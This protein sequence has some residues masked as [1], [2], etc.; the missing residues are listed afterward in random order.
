MDQDEILAATTTMRLQTADWLDTLTDSQ[1]DAPSLCEAWRVRDVAG[2]LAAALTV[3]MGTL[4]WETARAGFKPHGANVVIGRRCGEQH[5]ARTLREHAGDRLDLPIV[6]VHGQLTDLQVHNADMRVPLGAPWSPDPR[7]AAES[8]RFLEGG[9][10]GFVPKRRV[11]G[12]RVVADDADVAWGE[13]AELR[14]SAYDLVLGLCERVSAFDRLT[15][16]GV[17]VLRARS[18]E[19]G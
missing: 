19:V 10:P 12:L 2:H 7:W 16:A 14:G 3:G 9:A 1:L 18:A 15:G 6:G 4:L 5:P 11:G 17:E 13:G 8:L